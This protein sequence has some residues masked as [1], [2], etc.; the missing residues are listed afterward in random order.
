MELPWIHICLYQPVM[1]NTSRLLTEVYTPTSLLV[2]LVWCIYQWLMTTWMPAP[3]KY[4]MVTLGFFQALR[5]GQRLLECIIKQIMGQH[6]G[7]Q[8]GTKDTKWCRPH[9]SKRIQHLS[10]SLKL[11]MT[12]RPLTMW[13]LDSWICICDSPLEEPGGR[14]QF[15][16]TDTI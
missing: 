6:W 5:S 1:N 4:S 11:N 12:F 7:T 3:G 15:T 9:C 16:W 8:K 10:E 13:N 2:S 14:I